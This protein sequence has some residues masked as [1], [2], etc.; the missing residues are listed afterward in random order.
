MKK[1]SIVVY[2]DED[3]NIIDAK[4]V[5]Q[6]EIQYGE[7]ERKANKKIAGGAVVSRIYTPNG[8]CWRLVNG[9]WQCSPSYCS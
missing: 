4:N 3:G 1:A 5:D 9:M 2:V 6:T 8:C 7:E